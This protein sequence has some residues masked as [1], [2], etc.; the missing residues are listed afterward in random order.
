MFQSL[1]IVK[2]DCVLLVQP[3]IKKKIEIRLTGYAG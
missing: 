2:E 1:R 3:A